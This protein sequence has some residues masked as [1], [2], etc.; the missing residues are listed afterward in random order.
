MKNLTKVAFLAAAMVAAGGCA[1]HTEPSTEFAAEGEIRSP[2]RVAEIQRANGAREDGNLL[3]AHFT[4]DAVNSLGRA[5]LDAMLSDDE[6]VRPV[7]VHMEPASDQAASMRRMESVTAYLK[8]NGL[9]DSQIRFV[10]GLNERSY[11]PS[12]PNLANLSKT[13]TGDPSA[14]AA[15]APVAAPA[16]QSSPSPTL[17]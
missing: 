2:R 7:T 8:D 9:T 12:A 11:H 15:P 4:E 3:A 14:V 5:K 6:V 10:T 16:M 1:E 13:D 17:R